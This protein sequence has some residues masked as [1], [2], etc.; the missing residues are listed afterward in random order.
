MATSTAVT[1]KQWIQSLRK[2][3]WISVDSSPGLVNKVA[4]AVAGLAAKAQQEVKPTLTVIPGLQ[5]VNPVRLAPIQLLHALAKITTPAIPNLAA[6]SSSWA[7]RRYIWAFD[8]TRDVAAPWLRL[9]QYSR[10]LDFHQKTLLSDDL[11]VAV[12]CY[13]TEKFFPVSDIANTTTAVESKLLGAYKQGRKWPDLVCTNSSGS[14]AYVVECKGSGSDWTEVRRQLTNGVRQVTAVGFLPSV[15]TERFVFATQLRDADILVHAID[16]PED[17]GTVERLRNVREDQVVLESAEIQNLSNAR[18]LSY[19]GDYG[20]AFKLL[21]SGVLE[22]YPA[23][24]AHHFEPERLTIGKVKAVGR[25]DRW[26][27]P[28]GGQVTVFRGLDQLV[29][30][31]LVARDQHP[32]GEAMN[33]PQEDS[34]REEAAYRLGDETA[35]GESFVTSIGRDGT[36]LRIGMQ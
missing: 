12:A 35:D 16:P 6:F 17:D 13:L 29:H 14:T 19:C 5:A 23:V 31:A 10:K 11:G 4:A 18:T 22:Q 3:A 34:L 15:A 20:S 1:K 9:S 28:E 36:I 33:S 21:P 26:E 27:T 30:K 24:A 25:T 7:E 8:P 2:D 32:T